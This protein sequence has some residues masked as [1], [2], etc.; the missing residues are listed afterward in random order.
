MYDIIAPA[1]GSIKPFALQISKRGR[2]IDTHAAQ[3]NAHSISDKILCARNSNNN[4]LHVLNRIHE[5]E[6]LR[7]QI[8]R[9]W[10]T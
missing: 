10:A 7:Q 2:I 5:T 4:N 8:G 1:A 6:T 9:D 3:M